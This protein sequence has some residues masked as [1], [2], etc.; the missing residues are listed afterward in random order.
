MSIEPEAMYYRMRIMLGLTEEPEFIFDVETEKDKMIGFMDICLE[1]GHK[2]SLEM[3]K[4]DA[5]PE[6]W[7]EPGAGADAE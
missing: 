4:Y 5:V 7:I 2:V 3:N 6:P 1:N